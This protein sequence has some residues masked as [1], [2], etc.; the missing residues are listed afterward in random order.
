[1]SA[2][3][4]APVTASPPTP[5]RR[6]RPRVEPMVIPDDFGFSKAHIAVPPHYADYVDR[7][8]IPA[9]LIR[10]RLGCLARDIRREHPGER[11]H[12]VCLLKGGNAFF[13]GLQGALRDL[14]LVGGE[15]A[16]P[17]TFDFIRAKSYAGTESTGAVEIGDFKPESWAGRHV[18]L[19]ED[20]VD[21]GTTLAALL[22]HI[23]ERTSPA[24]LEVACLLEKRTP[25]SNGFKAD[26]VGFSIPDHFVVGYC[27]D[28]NVRRNNHPAMWRREAKRQP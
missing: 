22:P 1:M 6:R 28:Y 5:R 2:P 8:L 14:A 10:D 18:V 23:L 27:L 25:R 26:Y 12:L 7:V 4:P 24:S 9:G 11:L 3:P 21:T 19:C 16:I 20:L 17:F 15:H 13:N